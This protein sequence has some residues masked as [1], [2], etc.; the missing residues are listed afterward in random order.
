MSKHQFQRSPRRVR[1]PIPHQKSA[2]ALDCFAEHKM[3]TSS[4]LPLRFMQEPKI[5]ENKAEAATCQSL[6]KFLYHGPASYF[7]NRLL[8]RKRRRRQGWC[9]YRSSEKRSK[10]SKTTYLL[11]GFGIEVIGLDDPWPGRE[12]RGARTNR[13]DLK[14]SLPSNLTFKAS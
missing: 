13:G 4:F 12:K 2:S 7:P 10:H 8:K 14:Q 6:Q 1:M 11:R 3:H 9:L 5:E